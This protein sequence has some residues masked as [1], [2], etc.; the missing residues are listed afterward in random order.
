MRIDDEEIRSWFADVL[1]AKSQDE[2]R[3]SRERIGEVNRQ[4]TQVRNQQDELLNLRLLKEI[5]ED[6]YGKK[7]TELRDREAALKLQVEANDRGRHETA[8]PSKRLNLLNHSA[9][10]GLGQIT[11][12]SGESSK[13]CV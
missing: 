13:S 7:A 11:P 10:N 12:R 1:R 9:A 8:S 5:D 3:E 2:H 4:L 6:T